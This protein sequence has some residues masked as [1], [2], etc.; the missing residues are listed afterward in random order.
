MKKTEYEDITSDFDPTLVSTSDFSQLRQCWIDTEPRPIGLFTEHGKKVSLHWNKLPEIKGYTHCC[1]R[2]CPQ[3]FAKKNV[4][5][6]NA[7]PVYSF[8]EKEIRVLFVPKNYEPFGLR[9][10]LV[11]HLQDPDRRSKAFLVSR[12]ENYRYIIEARTL[13]TTSDNSSLIIDHFSE[14][15]NSG[16]ADPACAFKRYSIEELGNIPSFRAEM[17]SIGYNF[18]LPKSGLT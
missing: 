11:S 6:G 10:L 2:E 17:K 7:L 3:C 16:N 5:E 12:D 13:P 1:G 8:R 15:L 14:A 4:W 9:S 18:P